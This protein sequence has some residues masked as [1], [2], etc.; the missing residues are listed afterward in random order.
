[1]RDPH[2]RLTKDLLNGGVYAELAEEDWDL[3]RPTLEENARL[4]GIP[5]EAR[6]SVDGRRPDPEEVYRKIVP[7]KVK[8]LQ[9]EEAWVAH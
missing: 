5:V 8:A 6:L 9:A 1:M 7:G 2:R 4:F 3:M